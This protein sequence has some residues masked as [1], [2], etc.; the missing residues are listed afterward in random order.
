MEW[1]VGALVG[2]VIGFIA[3]FGSAVG[4]TEY[5]AWRE[6]ERRKDDV[7]KL[8]SSEVAANKRRLESA[9]SKVTQSMEEG[10]PK[11]MA[12]APFVRAIFNT[13][14]T[15]LA[16]LP[17]VTRDA[18]LEF[19]ACL[20]DVDLIVEEWRWLESRWPIGEKRPDAVMPAIEKMQR[21]FSERAERALQRADEMLT[22]LEK[23]IG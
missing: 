11:R 2:G 1:L 16:L 23:A 5:T 14:V 22:G 18:V 19:Y 13:S 7:A 4:V 15:D 17:E 10:Q 12:G 9:V 6:R 21:V 3:A 20:D 8:L